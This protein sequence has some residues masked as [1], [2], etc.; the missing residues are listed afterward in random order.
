MAKP[1]CAQHEVALSISGAPNLWENN[2]DG[3]ANKGR[4]F[5]VHVFTNIQR[6]VP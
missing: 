5:A 4:D 2:K 6:E 1:W 3:D